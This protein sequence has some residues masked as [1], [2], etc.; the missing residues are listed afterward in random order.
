MVQEGVDAVIQFNGQPSSN[1][2]IAPGHGGR[3]HPD[4]HLR[5]RRPRHVLRRH[6]QP[7]G[8][9]R[10]RR[11]ARHDHQGE[12][13]LQPRPRDL[14]RRR[15][16]RHRQR[17]A[18]RRH[19]HR[20]Q[21]HLPGHPGR[22]VRLVR[23]SAATPR[24][25]CQPAA[26]CSPPIPMP[27]KMAVV[28]INDGG[29]LGLINAAEQ[30]G[31]ADEVIGWGQDGAFITGDNVNPHLAGSVFYFLEGYAVYAIRDVIEPIADGNPPA[32]QGR[33]RRSGL[34]GRAVPGL[35]RA[36]RGRAG[37]AG[38]RRPASGRAVP[39]RPNTT[40]SAPTSKRRPTGTRADVPRPSHGCDT[41][42]RRCRSRSASR[43]GA[44]RSRSSPCGCC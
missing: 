16:R 35:G 30:L 2:A 26:T 40:S 41:P 7:R 3:R 22:E 6:R 32:A 1:P 42:L 4:R 25:P 8:G 28:G 43:A 34:A 10:R 18:H 17:V 20:R 33:C 13:G 23:G 39:A 9:H 14:V 37:H 24:S 12:V 15:W 31:R 19:A 11:A 27:V 44:R 36:G 38:A 21:E 29:V 5:H